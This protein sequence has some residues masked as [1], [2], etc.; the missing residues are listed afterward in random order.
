VIKKYRREDALHGDAG[1]VHPVATIIHQQLI[2]IPTTA[3]T[4]SSTPALTCRKLS[5][6]I[7]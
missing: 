6:M 7:F 5:E 2:T 3:T 4:Y 1:V